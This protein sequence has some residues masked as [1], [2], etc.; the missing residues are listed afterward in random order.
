MPG[1][2]SAKVLNSETDLIGIRCNSYVSLPKVVGGP[3]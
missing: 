1:R 2:V 3:Q